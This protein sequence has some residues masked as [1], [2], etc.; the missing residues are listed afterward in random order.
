MYDPAL[1]LGIVVSFDCNN[2][3][4]RLVGRPASRVVRVLALGLEGCGFA[5]QPRRTL[6]TDY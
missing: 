5:P 2:P 3:T 6:G 1:Y 4:T